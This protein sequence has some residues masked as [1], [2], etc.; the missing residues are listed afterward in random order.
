M[1]KVIIGIVE[2]KMLLHSYLSFKIF[3]SFLEYSI[4]TFLIINEF[5]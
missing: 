5:S 1:R 3:Q 4:T 2:E